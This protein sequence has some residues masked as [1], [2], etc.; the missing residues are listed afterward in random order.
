MTTLDVSGLVRPHLVE[1]TKREDNPNA[2]EFR[3]QPLE[4]GYGYTLGNALRRMLLSSLRGAAVWAFRLDGVVH[5]HQTIPGVVEDVHQIIQRLKQLTLILAPEV[6]EAVL[7]IRHDKTGPVYARDIEA[8]GSVTIVN[9][10]QLLFTVQDAKDIGG[11]LYVNKGRGYVEAE[12]HPVDRT[13]PV[14]V[15][16]I[17]SIYNPVRRANFTVAETRVG[18]RTDYDRLTL[19]VETNGTI[20]PEDAVAYAAA[21]AQ[22]HFRFFVDFGKVPMVAAESS[23]D[24]GDTQAGLRATLARSIDDVGLSV[25]SVNSLKNSN[26]LTLGDLV[27]YRED[28]LLKVKNVGEKALGEIAELLRREGLNFGMR[29]EELNGEIR[30]LDEGS[31]PAT[32]FTAGE[33]L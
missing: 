17:D 25:R 8:Q 19:T 30:V 13:L 28:D 22:E 16:R 14:D 11:D 21:L 23:E 27:Q 18:Q 10:D 33:E 6:D 4:R 29:W 9:P 32:P 15:V 31:A 7:H 3:L 5:E 1:M 12:Q 26:I 2:A 20:S 24:G